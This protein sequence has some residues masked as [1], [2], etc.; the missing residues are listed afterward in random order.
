MTLRQTLVEFGY[1]SHL[2]AEMCRCPFHGDT[3][4]SAY[5]HPSHIYCF[6]C[7]RKYTYVEIARHLHVYIDYEPYNQSQIEA[8]RSSV[9]FGDN[10]ECSLPRN[11]V[12]FEYPFT[13]TPL[14]SI[15][16]PL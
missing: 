5:M 12:L 4:P 16:K 7:G 15:I 10:G 1:A 3:N 9:F 13:V 6:A 14:P 2:E 8:S 11:S